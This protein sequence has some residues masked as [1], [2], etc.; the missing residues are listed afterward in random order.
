MGFRNDDDDSAGAWMSVTEKSRVQMDSAATNRDEEDSKLIY[1][2]KPSGRV[3]DNEKT[4]VV[5]AA[6]SMMSGIS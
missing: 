2:L 1:K 6:A 5:A 4:T 3:D